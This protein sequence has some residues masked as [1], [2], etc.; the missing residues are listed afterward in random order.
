[1]YIMFREMQEFVM[2]LQ[3]VVF[4]HL[5]AHPP[6]QDHPRPAKNIK[7]ERVRGGEPS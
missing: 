7:I 4:D 6:W 2:N 1:M 5:P 3:E